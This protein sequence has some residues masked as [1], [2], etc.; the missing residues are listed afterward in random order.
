MTLPFS[1]NTRLQNF[2]IGSLAL[3]MCAVCL[4]GVVRSYCSVP[5]WDMWNGELEFYQRVLAGDVSAWYYQHNEH[6]LVVPR[7]FFYLDMRFF[8]GRSAF[9]LGSQL[10]A[11]ALSAWL[12]ARLAWEA[13]PGANRFGVVSLI[14][15]AMFNWSQENNFTWAFQVQFLLVYTF[16][17]AA[18]FLFSRPFDSAKTLGWNG[19][20]GALCATAAAG[21]MANGLFVLPFCA[22][23]VFVGHQRRKQA[24]LLAVLSCVVWTAYL[25]NYASINGHASPLQSL[26]HHPL[27]VL[28]YLSK[29]LGSPFLFLSSHSV[30]LIGALG[31]FGLPALAGAAIAHDKALRHRASSSALLWLAGFILLS[32]L[33]TALGRLNFGTDQAIASRYST[34]ATIYWV[35]ML[36]WVFANVRWPAA[37]QICS[38]STAL[39]L[40]ALALAQ[41]PALTRPV[42]VFERRL[43]AVSLALAV[44]DEQAEAH[45]YPFNAQ[46]REISRFAVANR[47]SVFSEAWL[48]GAISR[49]GYVLP[50]KIDRQCRGNFETIK[51]LAG[52]RFQAK[53]WALPEPDV[54]EDAVWFVDEQMHV[55]GIGAWGESRPDVKLMLP[56]GTAFS[57]WRG[58]L[59]GKA[60]GA[61]SAIMLGKNSGACR[62][63]PPQPQP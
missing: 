18:F 7:L 17:I 3:W 26:L 24:L 14:L 8:N 4:A 21:C 12:V 62:I 61:V 43:A 36:A 42:P 10:L 25:W 13:R 52:N 1:Q 39:M 27:D 51:A 48:T 30:A 57:G 59:V 32:A 2:A 5:F 35:S 38:V 45:V 6:R 22:A 34:P 53:G 9:I 16:T 56:G 19:L 29:Y 37:R 20:A 50:V 23:Y 44:E 11:H 33:L 63:G 15:A 46:L 58:Y 40:A 47:L 49:L 60:E 28:V 54:S 31:L 55:L 41:T